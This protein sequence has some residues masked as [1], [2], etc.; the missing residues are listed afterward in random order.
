MSGA[1]FEVRDVGNPAAIL[2][3]PE[4]VDVIFRDSFVVSQTQA[5]LIDYIQQHTNLIGFCVLAIRLHRQRASNLFMTINSM[6]S[7]NSRKSKSEPF[8]QR[9]ELAK[10]N[11]SASAAS[12]QNSLEPRHN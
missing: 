1:S 9:L 6:A 3:G 10:R 4:N 8:K 12:Y 11:D 2:V 5:E 7:A